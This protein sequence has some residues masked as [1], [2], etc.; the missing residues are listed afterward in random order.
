[1]PES[2]AERFIKQLAR[3]EEIIEA[4][5]ER[6]RGD[7]SVAVAQFVIE[8]RPDLQMPDYVNEVYAA[9]QAICFWDDSWRAIT[10]R[11]LAAE[12]HDDIRERLL[13]E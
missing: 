12:I 6:C 7:I 9:Y 5:G 8:R 4:R 3:V 13:D 11:V 10:A 1:M 2:K